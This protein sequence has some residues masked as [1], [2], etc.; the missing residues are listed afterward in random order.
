MVKGKLMGSLGGFMGRSG[1][2]RALAV[3]AVTYGGIKAFNY[4]DGDGSG[5]SSYG[6]ADQ[7]AQYANLGHHFQSAAY[8]RDSKAPETTSV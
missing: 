4:L 5:A 7:N 3:G 6:A 1:L 8:G 2:G